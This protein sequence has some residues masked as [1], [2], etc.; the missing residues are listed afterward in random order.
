L[1]SWIRPWIF[2]SCAF[3]RKPFFCIAILIAFIHD[4][5]VIY[6]NLEELMSSRLSRVT[7]QLL[8]L[9]TIYPIN[10][11]FVTKKKY[12]SVLNN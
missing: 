11:N 1:K 2:P 12:I 5:P 9:V 7:N 10:K 4:S 8:S 6:L 3:S